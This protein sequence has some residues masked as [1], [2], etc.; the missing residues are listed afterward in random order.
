MNDA[1]LEEQRMVSYTVIYSIIKHEQTFSLYHCSIFIF[2]YNQ[3]QRWPYKT[4]CLQQLCSSSFPFLFHRVKSLVLSLRQLDRSQHWTCITRFCEMLMLPSGGIF[5]MRCWKKSCDRIFKPWCFELAW[6]NQFRV[7]N[8]SDSDCA[9]ILNESDVKNIYILKCKHVSL[10]AN[11]QGEGW[12]GR[13]KT[14]T[15]FPQL[16]LGVNVG[17]STV[18]TSTALSR[19]EE[20]H[21]GFSPEILSVARHPHLLQSS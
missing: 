1:C 13:K 17:H 16:A 10:R 6:Q 5:K 9:S 20:K 14:S 18:S 2:K 8:C 15:S 11:Q 4:Q 12:L 19:S 21:T 3:A 7:K